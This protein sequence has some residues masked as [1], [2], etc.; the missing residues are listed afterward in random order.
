[1]GRMV[2]V[3]LNDRDK[4]KGEERSVGEV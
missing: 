1:L 3:K 2:S 4:N